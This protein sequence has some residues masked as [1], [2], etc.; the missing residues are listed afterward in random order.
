MQDLLHRLYK[1]KLTILAMLLTVV[2]LGLLFLAHWAAGQPNWS[3]LHNLPVSDI[4]SGLFT[5]GLLAVA[6]QYF[7]GEVADARTVRLFH[8]VVKEE[9]PSIRD[10]V[11]DGF[12][13]NAEDLARVTNDK[14]LDQITRNAL[15]LQLGD[16]GLAADVYADI[17]QQVI[18]SPE[19]RKNCIITVDL[20][21]WDGGKDEPAMFVATVRHDYRV[22][23]TRPE[24]RF[25]ATSDQ[26]EY[27]DL[28]LDP[29]S[30]LVWYFKPVGDL[31]GG[32]TEA[33]ELLQFTVDGRDQVIRRSKRN[34]G[35]SFTVTPSG[36]PSDDEG[37]PSSSPRE[38][39]VSY[40]YR[41]LVRQH[42]HLLYLNVG[43]STKGL[44]IALRYGGCGI[45]SVNTLPFIASATPSRLSQTPASVPTPAVEVSFD[46][47]VWP[48]S[49][50][51]FV[52]ELES[53]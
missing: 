36:R 24:M 17:R 40:T 53:E 16:S 35:Q 13:F 38:V 52:W 50:V 43:T 1:A 22:V 25:S 30:G 5:T 6:W 33:F 23:P 11:I 44:K 2:G 7:T 19:R 41:V 45:R 42:G 51:T 31:H 47:W 34:R 49:G 46:G 27:R 28:L 20:A 48:R 3:G 21:P 8:R 10:A 9:V 39:T 15:A 29:Q 4:G 14:T 26:Q 12:A 18:Q 37:G 32:S